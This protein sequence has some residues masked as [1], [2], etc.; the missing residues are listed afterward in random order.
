MSNEY[1]Y[2]F[3]LLLIGDSAV[4]KS[5]LLL[6]F[7]D[8]SYVD[9]YI[10]TIGVDFKIRTVELDGKTV[11]LQIWDTAG[12]ERFRTITSSYY[13]GA[14]GIIIVY[15]VTEMESFNNVKQWL[16]E[17]DRYAS[18]NVSKLL[19]GNKCDL[20]ENKVVDTEKAKAFLTMAAEIKKRMGNQPTSNRKAA[21]TV[22]LKGQPIQQKSNCCG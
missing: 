7:A 10:S 22:P 4:G 12:Q 18:D 21:T 13:R 1:D 20:V 17:I 16:N 9:S 6:R 3:K 11:K 14:H 8:D 5:C 19:V 2:L 15:D